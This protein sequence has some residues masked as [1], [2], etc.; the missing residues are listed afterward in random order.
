MATSASLYASDS[1]DALDASAMYESAFRYDSPIRSAP[2][3]RFSDT[4]RAAISSPPVASTAIAPVATTAARLYCVES[5]LSGVSCD[6]WY[7]L[8]GQVMNITAGIPCCI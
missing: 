5:C 4:T 7:Q 8:S 3:E 1:D 2:R 6:E